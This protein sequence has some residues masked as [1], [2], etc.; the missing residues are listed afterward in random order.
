MMK[1]GFCGGLNKANVISAE[2]TSLL[3]SAIF[4][5]CSFSCT[6]LI[7][8]ATKQASEI[9]GEIKINRKNRKVI[10]IY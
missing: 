2:M 3:L 9:N 10:G 1:N 5:I 8:N 4:L 6:N 7:Q